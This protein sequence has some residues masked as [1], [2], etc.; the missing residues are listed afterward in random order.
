MITASGRAS[1]IPLEALFEKGLPHF[2]DPK[3]KS[4]RR[5]VP[6]VGDYKAADVFDYSTT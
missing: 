2:S 4:L 5:Y 6:D 1:R 3:L